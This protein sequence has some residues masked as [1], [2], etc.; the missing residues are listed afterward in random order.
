VGDTEKEREE[1]WERLQ[2]SAKQLGEELSEY[3]NLVEPDEGYY[4]YYFRRER[5]LFARCYSKESRML[6]G[7]TEELDK[8]DCEFYKD[9]EEGE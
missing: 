8:I 9:E 4:Y 7:F 5:G 3:R 2:D 1:A 6:S